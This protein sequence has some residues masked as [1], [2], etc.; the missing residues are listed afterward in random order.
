MDYNEALELYFEYTPTLSGKTRDTYHRA[1]QLWHEFSPPALDALGDADR[2]ILVRFLNWLLEYTYDPAHDRRFRITTALTYISPMRA[3]FAW[4]YAQKYLPDALPVGAMLLGLKHALKGMRHSP[5]PPSPPDIG[6]LLDLVDT[7][8]VD[9]A[10]AQSGDPERILRAQLTIL[11]NRA[12][13]HTL[14]ETGGRISEVLS[15]T[16]GDFP[17]SAWDGPLWTVTVTGKRRHEY[18][19]WLQDARPYLRAY[20]EK[21]A[22]LEMLTDDAPIFVSHYRKRN[23]GA[24]SRQAVAS[25][26]DTLRRR[27]SLP[28]V[29]PHDFRHWRATQLRSLGWS[30][31]DIA[32]H[33]GH[34]SVR[35]TEMY[36]ARTKEERI[37]NLLTRKEVVTS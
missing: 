18:K 8:T 26:V 24:L 6:A 5:T 36:Y 13:L 14:A 11:R 17:A 10:T 27:A 34:R 35:T 1:L 16:V 15:L 20:I 28:P 3:L 22:I 9:A 30:M 7:A 32:A 2:H 19:L 37:A 23:G 4:L 12:L 31:E 21:R 29:T 33:L 25:L